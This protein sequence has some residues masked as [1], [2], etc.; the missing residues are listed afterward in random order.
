MHVCNQVRDERISS[1]A[2]PLMLRSH[3]SL[4]CQV[5]L[6]GTNGRT[7]ALFG[8]MTLDHILS[9][10]L[11]GATIKVI[12]KVRFAIN[13]TALFHRLLSRGMHSESERSLLSSTHQC[14][15]RLSRAGAE[16]DQIV[17]YT[18]RSLVDLLCE[19]CASRHTPHCAEIGETDLLQTYGTKCDLNVKRAYD[20]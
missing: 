12:G 15:R 3:A 8:T 20:L 17:L 18:K 7:R 9:I 5:L 10:R 19:T 11:D 2:P 13:S 14:A 6:R 1:F 16:S 4:T